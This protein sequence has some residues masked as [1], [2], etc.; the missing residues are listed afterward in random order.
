MDSKALVEALLDEAF[1]I[2][3][4][5]TGEHDPEYVRQRNELRRRFQQVLESRSSVQSPA[6][7]P[8]INSP[9]KNRASE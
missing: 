4:H 6:C 2:L 8:S 1:R 5:D 3:Q 9:R 7:T